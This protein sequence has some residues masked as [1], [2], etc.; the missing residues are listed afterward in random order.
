MINSGCRVNLVYTE[1]LLASLEENT[2][3]KVHRV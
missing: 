1:A 3:M 2:F